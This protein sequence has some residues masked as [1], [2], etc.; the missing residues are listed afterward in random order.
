M[1]GAAVNDSTYWNLQ[2][3][4]AIIKQSKSK[5]IPIAVKLIAVTHSVIPEKFD[6]GT[7]TLHPG[8]GSCTPEFLAQSL[9]DW[10]AANNVDPVTG[11]PVKGKLQECGLDDVI[12]YMEK[13][14]ALTN[15]KLQ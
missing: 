7:P 3:A 5:N 14:L 4:Q 10:Y 11:C 12:P 6:D 2:N 13:A 1:I 8:K 15:Q 9:A